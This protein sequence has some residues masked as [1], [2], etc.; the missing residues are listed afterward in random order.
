MSDFPDLQTALRTA[1]DL[2]A[3]NMHDFQHPGTVKHHPS[4]NE[5]LHEFFFIKDEGKTKTWQQTQSKTLSAESALKGKT[6]LQAL[7]AFVEGLGLSG[8]AGS[9]LGDG[10][11]RI[12][13]EALKGMREKAERLR[14]LFC[15]II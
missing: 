7:V 9:G 15:K 12:E 4:G 8:S 13:C 5:L 6:Q 11:T 1:D 10:T 2:I 14:S 3:S